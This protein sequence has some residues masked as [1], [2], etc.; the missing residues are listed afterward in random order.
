MSNCPASKKWLIVNANLSLHTHSEEFPGISLAV[1]VRLG[2]RD[3]G[4]TRRDLKDRTPDVGG[5]RLEL[6][7]D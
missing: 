7:S 5:I 6:E 4:L 2:A 1:R 3:W